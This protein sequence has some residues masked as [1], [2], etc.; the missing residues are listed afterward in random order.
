MDNRLKYYIVASITGKADW[1]T[2]VAASR[3][4]E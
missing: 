2:Q 1:Q 4:S 3:L